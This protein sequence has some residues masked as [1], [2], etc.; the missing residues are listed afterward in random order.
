MRHLEH[1]EAAARH[2]IRLVETASTTA[3]AA[4]LAM[5]FLAGQTLA[6]EPRW[7]GGA[8]W[9]L[10]FALVAGGVELRH[11]SRER[12]YRH[13]MLVELMVAD[14]EAHGLQVVDTRGVRRG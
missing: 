13:R 9:L 2:R 10:G 4:G 11:R 8:L 6:A 12:A 1:L 3:Y 7:H 14:A 5:C